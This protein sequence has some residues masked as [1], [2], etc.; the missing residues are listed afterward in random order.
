[1]K[2]P[3]LVKGSKAAKLYMAKIRAKRKVGA[4]KK[5]V[6]KKAATKKIVGVEKLYCIKKDGLYLTRRTLS[7]P[8]TFTDNAEFR[9]LWYENEKKEAEKIAEHFNA[10]LIP[11]KMHKITGAK[12]K[13]AATKKATSTH[14]D[15]K[16]HNVNIKVVSGLSKAKKLQKELKSKKLKLTHGYKL[17][18]RKIGGLK[19]T[20]HQNAVNAFKLA[21]A[22]MEK[23]EKYLAETKHLLATKK[24]PAISKQQIADRKKDVKKLTAML[25]EQKTHLSVLKKLL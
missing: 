14:K 18:K 19:V 7:A 16:S 5:K 23:T 13:K 17:E 2:K 6:V 25:K 9:Y 11:D 4:V 20:Y 3:H 22:E 24:Y 8:L 15:T 21:S 12:N 10:K 1:M